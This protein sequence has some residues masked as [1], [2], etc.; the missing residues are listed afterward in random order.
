MH[1]IFSLARASVIQPLILQSWFLTF[2]ALN[3]F[4]FNAL[5]YLES[6]IEERIYKTYRDNFAYPMRKEFGKIIL[7]ILCQVILCFLIKLIVLV[8]YNDKKN[9]E[10]DV[11]RYYKSEEKFYIDNSIVEIANK[12]EKDHFLKRLIGGLIMLIIVTFFFYYCIVFCGIYIKTQWCWIYSTIW[13][14]LWIYVVFSP[15]YILIITFLEKKIIL[16]EPKLHYIKR[17]FIF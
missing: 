17:L 15:L 14:M 2:N 9:L 5:L 8:P 10:K 3:L 12:F 16:E 13:S 7:S 1:P 4:G 11:K 6:L